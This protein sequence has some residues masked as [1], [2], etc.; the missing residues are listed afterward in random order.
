MIRACLIILAIATSLP[1][2]TSAPTKLEEI[3]TKYQ[4]QL[5]L[6][7][8]RLISHYLLEMQNAARIE[9]EPAPY[10]AEV[11]R[12]Q[13]LIKQGGVIDLVEARAPQAAG[14]AMPMPMPMPVAPPKP[15]EAMQAVIALSPALSKGSVSPE[16]TAKIGE[17][18]WR[19][20]FMA[21]GTY[22]LH[23]EY[24]CPLL[25]KPLKIVVDLAGQKT[26]AELP[27]ESAT[28]DAQIFRVMRLG[29]VTLPADLR[30][31][32]LRITAGDKP[33]SSLIL[34]HLFITPAK[35]AS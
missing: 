19:V 34:R 14:A 35:P 26:E 21:A 7:H 15:K 18:E 20:V 6:R 12:L 17:M 29:R 11:A 30:G 1:A 5:R 4:L 23:L 9:P 31:R 25:S 13:E 32:D 10:L 8:M 27:L 22:D 16:P 2:Q 33:A 28:K 3:E 24:A